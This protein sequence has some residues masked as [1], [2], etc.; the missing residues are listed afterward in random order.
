MTRP[1]VLEVY[2]EQT[3]R[4]DGTR[5]AQWQFNIAAWTLIALGIYMSDKIKTAGIPIGYVAL[6]LLIFFIA[7]MIYV[8]RVQR[9]FESS[10]IITN[11]ILAELSKDNDPDRNI[12]I[13][14]PTLTK[15]VPIKRTGWWWIIF[16]ALAT[17]TLLAFFYLLV[18][19]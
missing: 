18:R 2:K 15:R 3:K 16:Q 5:R 8:W 4:F 6:L 1:E 12:V 14:I 7:H 11:Y 13:N 19:K 10:K 9:V 17:L